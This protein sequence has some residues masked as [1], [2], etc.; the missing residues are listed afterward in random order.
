MDPGLGGGVHRD[1]ASMM[2]LFDERLDGRA[3]LDRDVGP[4]GSTGDRGLDDL[5]EQTGLAPEVAIDRLDGDA[6]L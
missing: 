6:D 1:L 2:G 5:L 3:L 4:F